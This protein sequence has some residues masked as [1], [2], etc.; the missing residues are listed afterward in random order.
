M[1]T[2]ERV[3]IETL[4]PDLRKNSRNLDRYLDGD[5]SH[6]EEVRKNA[7]SGSWKKHLQR[8]VPLVKALSLELTPHYATAP[9]RVF[10]GVDSD[11]QELAQAYRSLRL[12]RKIAALAA[13]AVVQGTK[14]ALWTPIRSGARSWEIQSLSPWEC[15]V[16]PDPEAPTDITR[17]RAIRVRLARETSWDW[18]QYDIAELALPGADLRNVSLCSEATRLVQSGRSAAVWASDGTAVYDD[19]TKGLPLDQYP[20]A[21]WR[22]GESQTGCFW[23]PQPRYL[24]EAQVAIDLAM[25]GIEMGARFSSGQLWTNHPNGLPDEARLG[26]D[27]VLNLNNED[28]RLEHTPRPFDA[29]SYAESV[30]VYIAA[31]RLAV[32]LRPESYSGA[33]VTADAKL[34][35]L[36]T[37]G[38]LRADIQSA[39]V[40]GEL[41]MLRAACI[42]IGWRHGAGSAPLDVS[43]V[44]MIYSLPEPPRN[45]L[46]QAQAGEINARFG[47]EAAWEH[48]QR[49]ARE[50]GEEI[51]KPEAIRRVA[52]NRADWK[53]ANM[54]VMGPNPNGT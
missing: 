14:I 52:E 19:T 46:Q 32:G 15:E 2:A 16:Y 22:M 36:W 35:E 41:S 51:N 34:L 28:A 27:T 30:R 42:A 3:Q 7:F 25:S 23:G 4:I 50:R 17:A 9:V 53:A 48:V 5:H 1:L 40:E 33:A 38:T 47:V 45:P 6:T 12:N 20:V 11:R 31:F 37:Q 49:K 13:G 43:D 10:T 26:S 44:R 8:P 24:L 29:M 54:E 18:V 21:I 39:L